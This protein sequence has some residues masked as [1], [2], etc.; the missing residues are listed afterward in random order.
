MPLYEMVIFQTWFNPI[1]TG[2]SNLTPPPSPELNV[3][4]L[5]YVIRDCLTTAADYDA[6]FHYFFLLSSLDTSFD[7]RFAKIGPSV[8]RSLEVLYLHVGTK[9]AKNPHF[10]CLCTKHKEIFLKCTKTVFILSL[11]PFAQFLN[12]LKLIKIK[13]QQQNHKHNEIHKK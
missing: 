13:L 7:T 2:G 8:A 11:G 1:L 5:L 6:P 4:Y 10:A 12:I 9:F 3:S